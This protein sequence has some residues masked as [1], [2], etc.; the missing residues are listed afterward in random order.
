MCKLISGYGSDVSIKIGTERQNIDPDYHPY[1]RSKKHNDYIKNY[2]RWSDAS[3]CTHSVEEFLALDLS[4]NLFTEPVTIYS[5]LNL[6]S[7]Q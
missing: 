7:F 1:S 4:Y 5:L 3:F 6:F 2:M